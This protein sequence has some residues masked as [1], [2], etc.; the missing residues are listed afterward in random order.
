MSVG[1]LADGAARA[2]FEDAARRGSA[3]IVIPS[4]ALAGFD[5]LRALAQLEGCEVTYTSTKPP[6]AGKARRAKPR[7]GRIR[8]T[9]CW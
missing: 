4:G 6:S 1:V 7:S 3:R 5:G 2:R 9:K 8:R